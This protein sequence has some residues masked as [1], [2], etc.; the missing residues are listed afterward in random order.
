MKKMNKKIILLVD[1]S[2]QGEYL[3]CPFFLQ[4][5]LNDLFST[6]DFMTSRLI[7]VSF[8]IKSDQ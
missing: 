7:V 1:R 6:T 2:K 3:Y 4:I 8:V 5:T